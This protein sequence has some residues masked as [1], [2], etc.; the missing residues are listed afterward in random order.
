MSASNHY[1][2]SLSDRLKKSGM[3]H[4]FEAA[5]KEKDVSQMKRLLL[6]IDYT[7]QSADATIK[8]FLDDPKSFSI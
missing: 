1:G 2:L 5:V 7:S 4:R 3:T 6:S 8:T